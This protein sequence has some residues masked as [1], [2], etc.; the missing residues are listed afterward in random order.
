MNSGCEG[1]CALACGNATGCLTAKQIPF[2]NLV[3]VVSTSNRAS[4]IVTDERPCSDVVFVTI[5]NQ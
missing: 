1:L 5:A 3:R 4:V 2:L